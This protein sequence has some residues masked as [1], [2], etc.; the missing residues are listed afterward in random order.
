M[1]KIQNHIYIVLLVFIAAFVIGSFYDYPINSALFHE[2][3]TF[4]LVISV[5][6]TTPGYGVAAFIGGSAF[7]LGLKK[8]FNL[9]N[10]TSNALRI[11]IKVGLIALGVGA[12]GVSI[13]FTGREF[14]GPNGFNFIGVKRFWGYFIAFPVDA[15]IAVL[16]YY[17]ASKSKNEH[18]WI[19]IIVIGLCMT[20]ALV[21][22][23]T[24]FKAIFHRPR[25]R[26]VFYYETDYPGIRFHDWWQACSNYRSLLKEYPDVLDEEFKSFPSG[27]AC[28]AAVFMMGVTFLPLFDEKYKKL[29]FPLFYGG[30]AWLLL[31]SFAR[32][33]VG[34]HYLTDVSM[35]AIL[36]I[37]FFLL[38]RF[39]YNQIINKIEVEPAQKV[40]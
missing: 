5:I 18:L 16:G 26:T 4:G 15:A 9:G 22:G 2:R 25:F 12:F 11:L 6:G 38:G 13:F 21:G 27:H 37:L 17:L 39:V 32:M 3:D 20:F 10:P 40:E 35:G 33:Y 19:V 14:F 28:S 7:Y 1:K 24:L 23:T 29:E 36:A 30:L 34:A 8:E 31:V